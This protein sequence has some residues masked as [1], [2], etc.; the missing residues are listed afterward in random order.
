MAGIYNLQLAIDPEW[1][2]HPSA[3]SFFGFHGNKNQKKRMDGILWL[4]PLIPVDSIFKMLQEINFQ[5]WDHPDRSKDNDGWV[6]RSF[7][8]QDPERMSEIDID[9]R[10]GRCVVDS[11]IVFDGTTMWTV[12]LLKIVLRWCL[13]YLRFSHHPFHLNPSDMLTSCRTLAL[14]FMMLGVVSTHIP[15]I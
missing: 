5:N 8:C 2:D 1:V 13:S 3:P 6:G 15:L 14:F 9:V 11:S 10:M 7:G 4:L 12:Q